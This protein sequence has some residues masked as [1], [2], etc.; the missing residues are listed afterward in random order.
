M[1][2]KATDKPL[3]YEGLKKELDLLLSLLTQAN[4]LKLLD[5]TQ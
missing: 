2:Q 1:R 3:Y 5:S 4:A